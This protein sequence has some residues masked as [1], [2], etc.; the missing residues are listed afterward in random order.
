MN[1]MTKIRILIVLGVSGVLFGV[2]GWSLVRPSDAGD[3][4]TVVLNEKPFRVIITALFIGL[5]GALVGTLIGKPYGR[6]L[7]ML[8]IPAGLSVWSIQSGN[9]ERLLMNYPEAAART[10][11]F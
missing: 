11:M 7:G 2:W 1:G 8:A 3:G 6:Q 9:M 10:G 4:L 5:I